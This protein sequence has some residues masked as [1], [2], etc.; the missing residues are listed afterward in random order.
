[1]EDEIINEVL[2]DIIKNHNK[3][4]DDWCKAYLAQLYQENGTIKPGDFVLCQQEPIYFPLQSH[5]LVR[6]YWF[7]PKSNFDF[8]QDN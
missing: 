6:K 5:N 7:E 8:G 3:I 4:I 1:M 2:D